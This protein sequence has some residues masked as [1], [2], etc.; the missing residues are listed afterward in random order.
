MYICIEYVYVYRHVYMYVICIYVWN[1]YASLY[2]HPFSCVICM[3]IYVYVC[4][5]VWIFPI[6]CVAS[7]CVNQ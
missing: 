3:Y 2:V 1:M 6:C 7:L 4:A 5:S